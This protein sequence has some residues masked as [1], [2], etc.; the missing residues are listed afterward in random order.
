MNSKA[1]RKQLLAAVAM[2]L[3]AAVA[4]G[5]STYA[6]F[7]ASG[8]VEATGM[9]VQ[10]QSDGNLVIRYLERNWGTSATADMADFQ[11]LK[12]TS[13]SNLQQWVF[14]TAAAST[15]FTSNGEYKNV[16]NEVKP[17]VDDLGNPNDYA[18]VKHFQIRAATADTTALPTGL[19]VDSIDVTG[20]G[21]DGK[22]QQNLSV[23][24]R[25]GI[26]C[27]A[28]SDTTY[29]IYAPVSTTGNTPT[30]G[31]TVK[32][33]SGNTFT[34]ST[35][36]L[37]QAGWGTGEP[38][39]AIVAKDTPITNDTKSPVEVWVYVWFEGED[40]HL[41]SDNYAPENMSI[42]LK[43]QACSTKK[44]ELAPIDLTKGISVATVATQ[45][46]APGATDNTMTDYYK[47]TGKTAPG[48]VALYSST[49]GQ[50]TS[51]S[52]IVTISGT[53][54]DAQATEYTNV[55][56]PAASGG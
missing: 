10:A 55:T 4:L 56:K 46:K 18:L 34:D 3:V 54:N 19:Y 37:K 5:S 11:K 2:V 7:V 33:P 8:T 6:W 41:Y 42:S 17:T 50:V 13:T 14:S 26:K 9:K 15:A 30:D 12:P 23:S 49:S 22:P 16:T 39:N 24:L 44:T 28:G 21:A 38:L 51:S 52:T 48:G 29:S 47:I 32:V 27:V 40:T 45:A 1:I 20:T 25:V 36:T 35:V 53:G 31:Y 43:F